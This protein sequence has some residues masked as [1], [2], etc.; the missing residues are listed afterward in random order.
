M[1]HSD[2]RFDVPTIVLASV[3][4]YNWVLASHRY[5]PFGARSVRDSLS[6]G[7]RRVCQTLLWPKVLR[8]TGPLRVRVVRSL[9]RQRPDQG[10]LVK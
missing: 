7:L 1:G 6:Y 4:Y 9:G 3:G 10:L 2:D 8:A 5:C